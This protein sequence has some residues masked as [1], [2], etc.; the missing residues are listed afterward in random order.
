M[1]VMQLLHFGMH[2]LPWTIIRSEGSGDDLKLTVSFLG[3]GAKRLVARYAA[4]EVL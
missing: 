4:L 2:L 1:L 3:I